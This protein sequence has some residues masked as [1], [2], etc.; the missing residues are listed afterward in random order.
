MNFSNA[1]SSNLNLSNPTFVYNADGTVSLTYDYLSTLEG[2][3][4][5]FIFNPALASSAFYAVDSTTLSFKMTTNNNQPIT[6]YAPDT[7]T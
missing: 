4:A 6:Y 3:E 7:Y 5:V 1:F 2:E